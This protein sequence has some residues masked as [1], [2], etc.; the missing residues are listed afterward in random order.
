MKNR[1]HYV[2]VLITY[3]EITNSCRS[4]FNYFILSLCFSDLTS[5]TISP[6]FM[7]RRTWGYDDW[8]LSVAFCKVWYTSFTWF[9]KLLRNSRALLK[10]NACRVQACIN[11]H[12]VVEVLLLKYHPLKERKFVLEMLFFVVEN[13]VLEVFRYC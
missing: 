9:Q 10:P 7:Y 2:V 4:M 5:A 1:F 11:F 8:L 13:R 6:F 3:A 12:K